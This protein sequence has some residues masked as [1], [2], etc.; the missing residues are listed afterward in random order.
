MKAAAVVPTKA[1][2]WR[3]LIAPASQRPL[4][5]ASDRAS[6]PPSSSQIVATRCEPGPAALSVRI[7]LVHI[8]LLALRP[9]NLDTYLDLTVLRRRGNPKVVGR[10]LL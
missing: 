7:L 8:G 5:S 3:V 10:A 1:A 2:I 6:L 4:G 9:A